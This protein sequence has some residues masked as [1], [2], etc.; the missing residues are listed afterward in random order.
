MFKCKQCGRQFGANVP[1]LCPACGAVCN[2][3]HRDAHRLILFGVFG[4]FWEVAVF[5][6]LVALLIVLLTWLFG[7]G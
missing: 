7:W 2:T 5:A 1:E 6:V 4:A 3:E